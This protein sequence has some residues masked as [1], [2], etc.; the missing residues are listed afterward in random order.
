MD[1]RKQLPQVRM[2]EKNARS[3]H[4]RQVSKMEGNGQSLHYARNENNLYKIW[5]WLISSPADVA[6]QGF[7]VNYQED[8]LLALLV[9]GVKYSIQQRILIQVQQDEARVRA[10]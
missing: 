1:R 6:V 7:Q 9:A 2:L 4:A 8:I 3:S 5:T 10:F